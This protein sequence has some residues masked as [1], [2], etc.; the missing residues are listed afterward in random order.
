MTGNELLSGFAIVILFT[1]LQIFLSSKR[2]V[3]KHPPIFRRM[4]AA[5]KL[6]QSIGLAVEDGSR[7]HIALGS[8]AVIDSDNSSALSALGT[9]NRIEQLA[10]A[11]DLPP[12]CTSGSGTFQILSADI[13]SHNG[14]DS[15]ANPDL[16]HMPGV[17]PFSYAVG[18]VEAMKDASVSVNLFAGNF[19]AEAG[20]LCEA[21]RRGQSRSVAGSDSMVAQSIFYANA[22]ETLI[23]E[24][25]YAL[26]AYLS[27][28]AAYQ[29][30]L[31]G[32]D[33]L[34]LVVIFIMI[35]GVIMKV[36]GL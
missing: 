15:A 32:Q 7:L 1:L 34:R 5:E 27:P 25:L 21:S 18:A 35:G 20:W 13:A 36:I 8:S 33:I 17:T 14:I 23:G 28:R 31:R 11:S 26:P 24:E 2:Y 22:D 6:N 30:S 16:A 29:A 4:R 3:I 12:M 19:G 9:A 10:S